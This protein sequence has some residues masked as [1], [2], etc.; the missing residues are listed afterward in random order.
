MNVDILINRISIFH[1]ID[2]LFT[3]FF[4]KSDENKKETLNAKKY[5]YAISL[6]T[7][8]NKIEKATAKKVIEPQKSKIEAKKLSKGEASD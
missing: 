8:K 3:I 4:I 6:S 7:K 5:L 2:N 1:T